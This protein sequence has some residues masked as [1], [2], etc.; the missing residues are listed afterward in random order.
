MKF[1]YPLHIQFRFLTIGNQLTITDASGKELFY[2]EEKVLAVRESIRIF[3][4]A[5]EK[6]QIYGIKT[7]KIIDFG[8]EYF[9]YEGTD[10]TTPIGSLQEEGMR[11]LVKATYI[12]RNKDGVDRY[13]ITEQNP[14]INVANFLV[15]LIPY[16]ELVSG[17]F[18]NPSY[19]ITDLAQNKPILLLK[20]Q[21]SFW[22][23]QFI[24]ELLEKDVTDEETTILLGLIMMVLRQKERG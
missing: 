18:L 16:V 6:K 10:D 4:N 15:S 8:A 7:K 13:R 9:F 17:Y 12:I 19:E 24:V 11:S 3:N 2:I 5:Q 20:K 23:R 1:R 22:E 21:P 14:W